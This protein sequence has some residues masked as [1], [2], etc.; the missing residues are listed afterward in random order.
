VGL[1]NHEICYSLFY[2]PKRCGMP[3]MRLIAGIDREKERG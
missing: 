1:Y 2:F 3:N